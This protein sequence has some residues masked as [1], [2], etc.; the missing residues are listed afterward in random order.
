LEKERGEPVCGWYGVVNVDA[1]KGEG[2]LRLDE[3]CGEAGGR[4]RGAW[5]VTNDRGKC[6]GDCVK[7]GGRG[8]LGVK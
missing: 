1:W 5:D 3:N 8:Y 2:L 4:P 7:L 6:S